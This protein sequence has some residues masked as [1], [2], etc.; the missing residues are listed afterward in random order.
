MQM[1]LDSPEMKRL[2]DSVPATADRE[3]LQATY[4]KRERQLH[5]LQ[6][7]AAAIRVRCDE[8][9]RALPD[10]NAKAAKIL[11]DERRDLLAEQAALPMDLTVSAQLYADTLSDWAVVTIAQVREERR[12]LTV[13]INEGYPAYRE[14]EYA[15]KQFPVGAT[16]PA[17]AA[18]YAAFRKLVERQ[19]P[20]TDRSD[21]LRQL[22]ELITEFVKRALGAEPGVRH[23]IKVLNGRPLDIHVRQFVES[24]GKAA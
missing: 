10:A 23:T 8:I 6:E 18:A 11:Q 13:V 2:L 15:V 14:A 17:Y 4:L 5:T 22:E 20:Y 16:S 9:A 1:L 24:A 12:Q 3:R 19:K 21:D 7:R